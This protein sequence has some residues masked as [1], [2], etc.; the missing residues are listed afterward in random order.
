[1]EQVTCTRRWGALAVLAAVL[2]AFA[3]AF[4]L[5]GTAWADDFAAGLAP[6]NSEKGDSDYVDT[7][8]DSYAAAE[9]AD[10]VVLKLYKQEEGGTAELV[11]D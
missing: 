9:S 2:C 1:M 3:L 8:A 6:Q 7:S 10:T 4:G 5:S 11:K